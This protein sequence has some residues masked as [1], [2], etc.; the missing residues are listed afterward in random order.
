MYALLNLFCALASAT[1]FLRVSISDS[2]LSLSSLLSWSESII[3][4]SVSASSSVSLMFSSS[5]EVFIVFSSGS[6][7][8]ASSSVSLMFSSSCEVFIVFSSGSGISASSLF[9]SSAV[10]IVFSTASS[11]SRGTVFMTFSK[12][13]AVSIFRLATYPS[14]L[15]KYS[16]RYWYATF[17]ML[18]ICSFRSAGISFFSSLPFSLMIPFI[19]I[20]DST[21][22]INIPLIR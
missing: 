13:A 11:F 22:S 21:G 10:S 14:G 8:S 15:S 12:T 16:P 2:I 9:S 6:G 5:C 19:T 3:L 7:I 20:M 18:S 4:K 17:L 1:C